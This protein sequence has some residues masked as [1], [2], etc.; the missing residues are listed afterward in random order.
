MNDEL[1]LFAI[2]DSRA[3]G[4][5][6]AAHCGLKLAEHEERDFEDGE[7]KIRPLE[8]VRG[9]DVYVIQSLYTDSHHTVNDKLIRM[10]VF[11]GAL[12]D[13]SASQVTAVV[14]YLAYARKD[15]RTQP[16][17]PVTTRY[18]AQILE[19]VGT[20]RVVTLD[21][22]NLAAYQ[23]AF[24]IRSEHLEAKLI[25]VE[26][27]AAELRPDERVTVISPDA[28]GLKRAGYF[29][30][31]LSEAIG[32]DVSLGFMEKTRALGKLT[33]GELHGD[34]EGATAIIID[35]MIS[36][37][38]TLSSAAERARLH[39]ARKVVAAAS[40]GV[41]VGHAVRA[42]DTAALDRVI[43]TDSVPPIRLPADMVERKLSVLSCA[44]LFAAAIERLHRG[45]SLVEISRAG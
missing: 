12:R 5:Q 22:H 7:H 27:F 2:E 42:L 8:N 26:H 11:L 30:D 19:S 21:V 40:H 33:A 1:A 29:R 18:I 14:P 43:I 25:F 38:G 20:D 35:D 28:G 9:R 31:A 37:G 45:G 36:T 17:D 16:R 6:V 32:R 24:R 3:F 34:V 23:N 10:L 41:F 44:P 39:G 13:A 4:E 15:K